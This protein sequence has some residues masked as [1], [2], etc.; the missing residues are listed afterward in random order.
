MIR[1]ME[2]QKGRKMRIQTRM[3]CMAWTP[4]G[5]DVWV[6]AYVY[7]WVVLE[8]RPALNKH[9]LERLKDTR[10]VRCCVETHGGFVKATD[11]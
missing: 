10:A 2:E 3:G 5:L 6:Y 8:T 7:A 11:N 4:T 1:G 9:Y